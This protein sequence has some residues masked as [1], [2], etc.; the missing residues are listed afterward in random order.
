LVTRVALFSC[1]HQRLVQRDAPKFGHGVG[2]LSVLL[3]Y[4]EGGGGGP[5]GA[6]WDQWR[7]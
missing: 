2:G 6:S 1:L 5:A 4:L 7:M 3:A